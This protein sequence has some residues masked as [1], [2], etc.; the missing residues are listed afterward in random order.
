MLIKLLQP[1][2]FT[3]HVKPLPL[4]T[5]CPVAGMTCQISGWGSITSPEESYNFWLSFSL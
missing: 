4:A 2:R 5:S 1:A 3:Q